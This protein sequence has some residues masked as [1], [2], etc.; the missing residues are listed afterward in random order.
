MPSFKRTSI[1]D[2]N[3]PVTCATGLTAAH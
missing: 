3:V 2:P 1:A